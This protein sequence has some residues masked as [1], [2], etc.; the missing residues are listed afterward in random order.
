MT[1][2]FYADEF[3]RRYRELPLSVQKKAERRERIF[4][5]NPFHPSL[6]TEKLKPREKEYW[7]F[8]IDPS[9]RILFR[10]DNDNK[11]INF[12]TCG[13]H[14]WIYSYVATH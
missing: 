9:Y 12:L 1:E 11:K 2:I 7:S 14:S 10:F 4:R 13:H 5:L 3:K 6:G 8:R